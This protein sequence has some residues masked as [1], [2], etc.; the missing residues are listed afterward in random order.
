LAVG[1]IVS[2]NK[3]QQPN[4]PNIIVG[5]KTRKTLVGL[6]GFVL[7]SSD[8]STPIA[9]QTS[10]ICLIGFKS[11]T[12]MPSMRKPPKRSGENM[13]RHTK[14]NSTI[15]RKKDVI[16]IDRY[17]G[18]IDVID[19]LKPILF[20]LLIILFDGSGDINFSYCLDI[21]SYRYQYMYWYYN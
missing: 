4:T 8:Q 17:R 18:M 10:A 15:T 13:H 12:P 6:L 3:P 2:P 9:E 21:Y 11:P 16:C 20:Y 5:P 19:I 1:A 14:T 7:S